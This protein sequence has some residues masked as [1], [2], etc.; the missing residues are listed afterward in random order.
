YNKSAHAPDEASPLFKTSIFARD[1]AYAIPV[2]N[3]TYTVKTYHCEG[4]FGESGPSAVPGQRVFDIL[5]EGQVKKN[6]LDLYAEN[7]NKEITYTF[8]DIYVEDGFLNLDM[9]AS[10]N[11]AVISGFA[12]IPAGE[13][14]EMPGNHISVEGALFI[15]TGSYSDFT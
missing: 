7:G 10:A 3:G 1:M 9:K 14:F 5:I 6:D 13:A 11:N 8:Q 2:P 4:Y 15:K 12:V